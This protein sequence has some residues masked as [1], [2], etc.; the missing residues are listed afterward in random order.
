MVTHF[1]SPVWFIII[2]RGKTRGGEL[3]RRWLDGVYLGMRF[4]SGEHLVAMKNGRVVKARSLQPFPLERLW[5][6]ERIDG[7]V[8]VPWNPVG[9]AQRQAAENQEP[10]RPDADIDGE[11]QPGP[12]LSRGMPVLAKHLEKFGY[13]DNCRK[14]RKLRLGDRT[15]PT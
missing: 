2:F 13:T 15:Q 6:S 4:Q 12:G 10:Q 8:G 5:D 11:P 7:I 14:C 1:G 3:T 9:T